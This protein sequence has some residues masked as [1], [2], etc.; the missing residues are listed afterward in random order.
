[1]PYNFFAPK[2]GRFGV[3]PVVMTSGR[4][5]MVGLTGGVTQTHNMGAYSTKSYINKA[6]I[7]AETFPAAATSCRVELYKMTGA[8]A[9][10]L[11][12]TGGTAL[13]VNAATADVP[14]QIPILATLTDAQRTLTAGDSIRIAFVPVGT[15]STVGDDVS[16]NIELL[17]QE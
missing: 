5:N 3:H 2:P 15:V 4:M 14:I 16:V 6:V 17:V 8:T 9:L 13:S 11:T 12:A 10:A 1:M 7:C